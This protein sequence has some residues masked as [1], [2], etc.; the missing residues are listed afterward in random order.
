MFNLSQIDDLEKI[1]EENHK[2]I[3]HFKGENRSLQESITRLQE[4]IQIQERVSNELTENQEGTIH[5][6]EEK[7]QELET[8]IQYERMNYFNGD[9][10]RREKVI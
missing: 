7:M 3:L 8:Q 9:R 6:L 4:K 10:T 5:S 1:K 2:K